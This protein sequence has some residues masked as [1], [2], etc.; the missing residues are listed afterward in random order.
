MRCDETNACIVKVEVFA[1]NRAVLNGVIYWEA[2]GKGMLRRNYIV[3]FDVGDEM[4]RKIPVPR[5]CD[6]SLSWNLMAWR[7]SLAIFLCGRRGLSLRFDIWRMYNQ[8][9]RACSEP[10]TKIFTSALFSEVTE[11]MAIWKGDETVVQVLEACDDELLLH[12]Y[13]SGEMKNFGVNGA[14]YDY[15]AHNY[16]ESLISVHESNEVQE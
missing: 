6:N 1:R 9:H 4:V 10:L 16:V 7:G 12:D 5:D 15:K 13:N 14:R 8:F 3:S 11:P 2:I